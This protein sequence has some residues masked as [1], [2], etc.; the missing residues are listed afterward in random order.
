M[1]STLSCQKIRPGATGYPGRQGLSCLEGLS[2]ESV[3]ARAICMHL[4]T[5]PPGGRARAHKHLAHETA[6]DVLSGSAVMAWGERP[7]HRME[8]TAGRG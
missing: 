5:I 2:R 3:G 4:L 7:E 8:V 6:I 1:T